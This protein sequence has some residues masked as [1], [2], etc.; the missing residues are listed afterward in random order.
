MKQ[1]IKLLF[2]LVLVDTSHAGTPIQIANAGFEDGLTN[3]IAV[4]GGKACESVAEAAHAGSRGL[5]ISAVSGNAGVTFVSARFNATGGET[6]QLGCWS[7]TISGIGVA[8]YVR[9]YDNKGGLLSKPFDGNEI[10]VRLLPSQKEWSEKSSEGQAPPAAWQGEVAIVVEP[11]RVVEAD[12]DEIA[13][14]TTAAVTDESPRVTPV[15]VAATPAEPTTP[16]APAGSPEMISNGGFEGGKT[17][18][19]FWI[20]TDQKE[21]GCQWNVVADGARS[22]QNCAVAEST[23]AAQYAITSQRVSIKDGGRYH[24][25]AWVRGDAAVQVRSSTPGAMVRVTFWSA[26]KKTRIGKSVDVPAAQI[27]P[28]A[29]E[30]NKIEATFEAPAAAGAL[31]LSLYAQGTTGKLFWDDISVEAVAPAK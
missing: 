14:S 17:N 8:V 18:W 16:A 1:I 29:S 28:G 27:K 15:V 24:L 5:R 9:F 2:A 31:S 12:F 23:A 21:K 4:A 6:Y 26:D 3:W 25:I 20:P 7:R 11:G 13:V 10:F 22:G 19:G 30:W